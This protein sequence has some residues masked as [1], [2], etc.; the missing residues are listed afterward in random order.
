MILYTKYI[1]KTC[2]FAGQMKLIISSISSTVNNNRLHGNSR[3]SS[4]NV[5]TLTKK[6]AKASVEMSNEFQTDAWIKLAHVR[7]RTLY[8]NILCRFMQNETLH[9]RNEN[10]IACKIACNA[11]KQMRFDS[12]KKTC[13][14]KFKKAPTN[15]IEPRKIITQQLELYHCVFVTGYSTSSSSLS[16]MKC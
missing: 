6:S 16:S 10:T 13:E 8:R 11:T 3:R 15:F 14:C 12:R 7:L 2:S 9:P 4:L 5:S 1:I